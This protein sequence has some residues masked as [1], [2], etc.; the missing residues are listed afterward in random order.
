MIKVNFSETSE[1]GN[2]Q[3]VY[4]FCNTYC[5][6]IF[7]SVDLA[8]NVVTLTKGSARITIHPRYSSSSAMIQFYLANSHEGSAGGSNKYITKAIKTKNGVV[9]YSSN[10]SPHFINKSGNTIISFN[11][12]DNSTLANLNDST[13][14]TNLT[15]MTKVICN[16]TSFSPVI[17]PD[18]ITPTNGLYYTPFLQ[19]D[20]NFGT[21]STGNLNFACS[22][23]IA[24][25]D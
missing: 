6:D 16:S 5:L 18:S 8:N 20:L 3:E 22:G 12:K 15:S 21:I 24:L 4:N 13:D 10:N 2:A 23:Y 1:S 25:K 9:F 19:Y 17:V 7:D 11:P 14:F